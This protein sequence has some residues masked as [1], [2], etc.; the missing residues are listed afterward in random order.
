V[1]V[2]TTQATDTDLERI[3]R[4]RSSF[5]TVMA[6]LVDNTTQGA[7]VT[8]RPMPG[9]VIPIRVTPGRPFATAWAEALGRDRP[10]ARTIGARQ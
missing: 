4:L 1:V 8:R 6:V 10:L 5:P 9:P 2:T 7:S 3:G